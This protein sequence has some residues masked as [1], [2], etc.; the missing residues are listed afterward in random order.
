VCVCVCVCVR[1]SAALTTMGASV[2]YGVYALGKMTNGIAVDY[3]GGRP[4]FLVGLI[5]SAATSV[6][7]ALF[8]NLAGFTTMWSL[9]RFLQSVGWGALVKITSQWFD[10]HV[11][12]WA[13]GGGLCVCAFVCVWGGAHRAHD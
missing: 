8:D 4:L 6:F 11:R 2:G 1:A 12:A 9:N 3:L 13:L 10:S 5:G 7:F